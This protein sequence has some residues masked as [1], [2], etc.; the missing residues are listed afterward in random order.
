M[1]FAVRPP[2]LP[3]IT[4]L[5]RSV[6]FV[7]RRRADRLPK[8]LVKASP[9]AGHLQTPERGFAEPRASSRGRP[10][11]DD[12]AVGREGDANEVGLRPPG[13]A[14]DARAF[15]QTRLNYFHWRARPPCLQRARPPLRFELAPRPARRWRFPRPSTPH[16]L[17]GLA[18]LLA[19]RPSLTRTSP[20]RR[21]R[22]IPSRRCWRSGSTVPRRTRRLLRARCA[23]ARPRRAGSP[24]G[25]RCALR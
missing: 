3:L 25:C 10:A 7:Q 17:T 20:C 22:A 6:Q 16:R 1:F 8:R 23:A 24:S 15:G 13:S 4:A 21:P 2:P 14:T 19:K 18:Q 5:E 12:A 11:D 9:L